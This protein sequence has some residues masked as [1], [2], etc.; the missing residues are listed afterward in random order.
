[1]EMLL[2]QSMICVRV[3]VVVQKRVGERMI[4]IFDG[5]ILAKVLRVFPLLTRIVIYERK[6]KV[7][8]MIVDEEDNI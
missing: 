5:L 2:T 3:Y 6:K 4:V 7:D 1:M 8:V